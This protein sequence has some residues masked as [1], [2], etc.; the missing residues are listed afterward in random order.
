M[1]P[2]IILRNQCQTEFCWN[3]MNRM[4]NGENIYFIPG[5]GKHCT[6]PAISSPFND[7]VGDISSSKYS[8]T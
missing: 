1:I 8:S 2:R 7:F 5:N 6:E 4:W 3:E